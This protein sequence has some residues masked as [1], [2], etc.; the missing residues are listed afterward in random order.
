MVIKIVREEDVMF[1]FCIQP[2]NEYLWIVC[3]K[4]SKVG[5]NCGFNS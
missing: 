1:L 4:W 2:I 3:K 5:D